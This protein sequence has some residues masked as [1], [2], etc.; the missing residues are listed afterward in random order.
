MLTNIDILPLEEFEEIRSIKKPEII[1]LKKLRRFSV[2]PDITFYFEN[3]QT[4]WWQIQEMLRIEKGGKEQ[5]DDEI[6]AYTPMIP[7]NTQNSYE[8]SATMMI[9]IDDPVRRQFTLKQLFGIDKQV[10]INWQDTLIQSFSVDDVER[11]RESDQKTSSI[12]FLKWQLS[13]NQVSQFLTKEVNLTITNPHYCFK[14]VM[15][16]SLK[17]SLKDDFGL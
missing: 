10:S 15:P 16:S 12:H 17:N 11:N 14:E 7:T 3:T 1:A 5:I 6:S 4:I 13:S 8:I 2:G 9:E